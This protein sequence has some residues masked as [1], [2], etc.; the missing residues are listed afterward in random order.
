[1]CPIKALLHT[2][3]R[4]IM[5][6]SLNI[7][8]LK[9]FGAVSFQR[10]TTYVQCHIFLNLLAFDQHVSQNPKNVVTTEGKPQ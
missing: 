8:N 2:M 3:L 5:F 1:M 6:I 9:L 10:L 4:Y 7:S